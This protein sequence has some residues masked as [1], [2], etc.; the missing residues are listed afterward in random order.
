M[1]NLSDKCIR[2][3]KRLITYIK[4]N[5]WLDKTD[6]IL[7]TYPKS[8]TTW[9]RFIFAN[10]ISIKELNGEIVD[11]NILN[12]KFKASFDALTFNMPS[13][14]SMP[15]IIST[16]QI[17]KRRYFGNNRSI[18]LYRNPA[19]TMVSYYEYRKS[20][21]NN[22]Y[23]FD[24]KHFIRDKK[25]GLEAWCRHFN[26]WKDNPSTIL[27]YEDL[28]SNTFICIKRVLNKFGLCAFNDNEI[29]EAIKRSDFKNIQRLELE[30]GLD[31]AAQKKHKEN[32]RFARKGTV[33]QWV[34]YFESDDI[35]FMKLVLKK[36]NLLFLDPTSKFL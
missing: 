15:R 12:T 34:E 4:P 28:K 31:I 19:D 17:Y 2:N 27:S 18:L 7:A 35:A 13:F 10:L 21:K 24:F 30:R 3:F 36:H 26:S 22:Y 16:H 14:K 29:N 1:R 23:K 6:I 33:G 11:Y 32:F 20:L 5:V 25:Y 9:L 8:G